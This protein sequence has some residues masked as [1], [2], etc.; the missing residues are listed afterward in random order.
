MCVRLRR[1]AVCA[2]G[3]TGYVKKLEVDLPAQE[4]VSMSATMFVLRN[5]NKPC[6]SSPASRETPEQREQQLL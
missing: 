3:W 6:R 4:F 2:T 5:L 1:K